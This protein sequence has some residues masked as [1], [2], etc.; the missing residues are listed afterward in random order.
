[1]AI[2]WD[3]IEG[4]RQFKEKIEAY[5]KPRFYKIEKYVPR[6]GQTNFIFSFLPSEEPVRLS[7]NGITYYENV[8]FTVNRDAEPP[9]FTWIY[10]Q[11]NGGFDFESRDHCYAEYWSFARF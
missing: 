7:V 10:T 11:R 8:H 3:Q 5:A 4:G 6:K 1:M 2:S 9:T